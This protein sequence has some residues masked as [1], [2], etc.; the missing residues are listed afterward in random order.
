MSKFSD[1]DVSFA[2][3]GRSAYKEYPFPGLPGVTCF[4]RMLS[5]EVLDQTRLDAVNYCKNRQAD[6]LWD[7]EF[8]DRA[9]RRHV[10]QKAF[11]DPK[12]SKPFFNEHADVVKLDA[13][14]IA[15]L[16]ELYLAHCRA[17]DPLAH[18]S[19]EEVGALIDALKKGEMNPAGLSLFEPSTLVRFAISMAYMLLEKQPTPK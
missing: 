14:V 1:K 18:A 8:V 2:L 11:V 15:T 3:M 19:A 12:D 6:A 5:D 7:P 16:Y 10:I 4:V 9:I 17:A 13:H